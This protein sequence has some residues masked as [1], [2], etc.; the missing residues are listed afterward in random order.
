MPTL[1][2]R[3]KIVPRGGHANQAVVN[4]G[5]YIDSL[6]AAKRH[7]QTVT[8]P[9]LDWQPNLEVLLEDMTGSEICRVPYLGPEP[10]TS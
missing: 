2:F 5:L 8:A 3:Y 9:K 10:K 1:F 4:G 6:E 7:V